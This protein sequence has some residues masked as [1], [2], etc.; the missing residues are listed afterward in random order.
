MKNLQKI[1]I[2]LLLI[3]VTSTTYG[4]VITRLEPTKDPNIIQTAV[5]SIEKWGDGNIILTNGTYYIQKPI[6]FTDKFDITISKAP[7]SK[8]YVVLLGDKEYVSQYFP[9]KSHLIVRDLTFVIN[10]KIIGLKSKKTTVIFINN[11][12]ME[13]VT[14]LREVY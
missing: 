1:L 6:Q 11:K 12:M 9:S 8:V 5:K 10:E 3:F 13:V 2:S 14:P 4:Q 7:N